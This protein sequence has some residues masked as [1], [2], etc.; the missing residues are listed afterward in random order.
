MATISASAWTDSSIDCLCF[1]KEILL[2]SS[3]YVADAEISQMMAGVG[4]KG[5]GKG[6]TKPSC[7]WCTSKRELKYCC[8]VDNQKKDFCSEKC[9]HDYKVAFLKVTCSYCDAEITKNPVVVTEPKIK[10]FCNQTCLQKHNEKE[11]QNDKQKVKPAP[12]FQHEYEITGIFDWDVYLKECNAIAAPKECFKQHPVPPKN[13]FKIGQKLE[14]LDPRNATSTCIATIVGVQGPLLR[15]RLDGGDNAN[16]FWRLVD[17]SD[18]H[19]IGHC[20]KNGGMLQPPLGFR[21]NASSWPMFL[22]KTL[23]GASIAPADN[24]MEE[25]KA[26][27]CKFE[28]GFKLEALDR[29]NPHLICPATIGA[30]KEDM[31]FITFDGWRGAFDYWCKYDSR[32]IFPVGWCKA[33]GHLLQFPGNKAG[34]STKSKSK[35]GQAPTPI[36]TPTTGKPASPTSQ[37]PSTSTRSRSGVSNA[38]NNNSKDKR[39]SER[40]LPERRNSEKIYSERRNSEKVYSEKKVPE[41]IYSEKKVPE[42]IYSEKKTLDKIDVENNSFQQSNKDINLEKSPE[43]NGS[44]NKNSDIKIS[45]KTNSQNNDF[46]MKN[47]EL[48]YSEKNSPKKRSTEENDSSKNISEKSLERN[49]HFSQ[50][51]APRSTVSQFVSKIVTSPSKPSVP[52]PLSKVVITEPDTSSVSKIS[53]SVWAYINHGCTSG[54]YLNPRRILNLPVKFGP[55]SLNRVLREAVQSLIDSAENKK[56]VFNLLKKGNGKVLIKAI[57]DGKEETCH[58]PPVDKVDAFWRFLEN[59][60]EDLMCCENFYSRQPLKDGCTKCANK[61]LVRRASEECSVTNSESSVLGKRRWSSDSVENNNVSSISLMPPIKRP[62]PPKVLPKPEPNDD[63]PSTSVNSDRHQINPNDWSTDDVAGEIGA[64]DQSMSLYT[65]M[66]KKHD[67]DGKALLLLNSEMMMKYLGLK[68]GPALKVC[69]LIEKLKS[70]KF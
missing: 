43:K 52:K 62:N 26:P 48:N 60:F 57:I 41:K 11:S 61:G 6:R 30:V 37:T 58:L 5:S 44:L 25:P 46:E 51:V 67:I 21:M 19:P 27:R 7:A 40:V 70:R 18:I 47:L 3:Y 4:G 1:H 28:E 49:Q 33:S 53:P 31:I 34:S 2:A 55:G 14:A 23:N 32:D 35:S 20:E 39:N 69:N 59:L 24:F 50:D 29:K 8:C 13:D 63:V 17:S 12:T 65:D 15:L 54:P 42:K 36:S 38:T 45:I 22:L 66:F 10:D 64:L 9:L 16:D 68:L 56:D